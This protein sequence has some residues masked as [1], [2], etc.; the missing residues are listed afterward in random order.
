VQP[1][2]HYPTDPVT[3]GCF[4]SF[5]IPR[6]RFDTGRDQA[7]HQG[8]H[9]ERVAPGG[10]TD[11]G[12]EGHVGLAGELLDDGGGGP[13]G[14]LAGLDDHDV[15]KRTQGRCQATGRVELAGGL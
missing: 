2:Q 6:G 3:T 7:G 4:D 1:G 15:G 5:G 13:Q 9:Q 14:Q 12:G 11:R 10:A 8:A